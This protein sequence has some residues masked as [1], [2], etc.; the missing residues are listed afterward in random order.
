MGEVK[1]VIPRS[2]VIN[3]NTLEY[4]EILLSFVPSA[5]R[6]IT[7]VIVQVITD[8]YQSQIDDLFVTNAPS[9]SILRPSPSRK[10][11]ESLSLLVIC[12]LVGGF[13]IVAIE[14][15]VVIADCCDATE[16]ANEGL[17]DTV[18]ESEG[19]VEDWSPRGGGEGEY[20]GDN[21]PGERRSERERTKEDRERIDG[22]RCTLPG[23]GAAMR[24][25]PRLGERKSAMDTDSLNLARGLASAAGGEVE[26]GKCA[27]E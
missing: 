12:G 17:F 18:R 22:G 15:D 8:S 6:N 27:W 14:V 5:Q 20:G 11:P 23:L 16:D 13:L 1:S 19:R 25:L 2:N 9:P 3:K 4:G 7:S 21:R 24:V 10:V 26:F